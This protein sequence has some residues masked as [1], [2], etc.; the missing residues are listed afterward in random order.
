MTNVNVSV[1]EYI[2]TLSHSSSPTLILE[3]KTD[4]VAFEDFEI[5]N[6]G[7]GFTV[8][9]VDGKLNVLDLIRRRN[10]IENPNV[11]FLVDQDEWILCGVPQDY[12]RPDVFLTNG[13]AIENDLI[14]DGCPWELMTPAEKASYLLNL[15][16]FSTIYLRLAADHLAGNSTYNLR[17]HP[18]Q[19]FE[20]NGT[21]KPQVRAWIDSH[22]TPLTTPKHLQDRPEIY[23]R[24]KSLL[25]LITMQLSS[26]ARQ[27]RY[28]KANILEMG[29]RKRGENLTGHERAVLSYFERLAA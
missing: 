28:S 20:L 5:E 3:G 14:A 25:S 15:S 16:D 2:S 1:D 17:T 22:T 4:Y 10:E 12:V 26:P 24:G 18:M 21:V 9:P 13:A 6:V 27:S 8:M 19:F 7:W 23:V 29:A 11:I